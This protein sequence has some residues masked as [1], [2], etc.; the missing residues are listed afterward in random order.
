MTFLTLLHPS[1]TPVVYPDLI[2]D[3][4]TGNILVIT[5]AQWFTEVE[6]SAKIFRDQFPPGGWLP[7]R[8]KRKEI[9]D[10]KRAKIEAKRERRQEYVM[11]KILNELRGIENIDPELQALIDEFETPDE[12]LKSA[13]EIQAELNAAYMK[14]VVQ[15]EIRIGEQDQEDQEAIMAALSILL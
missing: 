6:L 11:R 2:I 7:H 8:R 4:E 12:V 10:T 3:T 15:R 14:Y 9:T 1:E 5:G 13:E